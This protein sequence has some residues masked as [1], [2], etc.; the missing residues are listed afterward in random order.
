MRRRLLQ[1]PLHDE[2][3]LDWLSAHQVLLNDAFQDRRVARVVPRALGIDDRDGSALADAQ[4]IGL[5]ALDAALFGQFQFAQTSLQIIPRLVAAFFVTALGNCLIA[6]EED[7]PSRRRYANVLRDGALGFALGGLHRATY[8]PA[9]AA[10][11][12]P[13]RNPAA[14]CPPYRDRQPSCRTSCA[15]RRRAV[16]RSCAA[17]RRLHR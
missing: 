13:S 2:K 1:A 9:C 14:P 17:C 6:T 10:I 12:A 16:R 15:R 4:T 11:Q 7:V 3:L 5:G 8:P